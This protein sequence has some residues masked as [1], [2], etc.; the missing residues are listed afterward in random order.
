MKNIYNIIS[1]ILFLL[2]TCCNEKDW[3][4]IS[5]YGAIT[6]TEFNTVDNVEKLCIAAYAAVGNDANNSP[7]S[8]W[9]FNFSVGDAHKGG[10]TPTD[11]IDWHNMEVLSSLVP[12]NTAVFMEWRYRMTNIFRAN[13]ALSKLI[14][15]TAA[16]YPLVVQRTAEMRFLRAFNYFEMKCMF[17]FVPWLD[18]TVPQE[19]YINISNTQF[20]SDQLWD[21]IAAD[22]RFCANNLPAQQTT[23]KGRPDK[24][25]ALAYLAKTYLFQAYTQDNNNQVTGINASK[26]TAVN[27]L[28]D[29]IISFSG[30]SMYADYA[31][32]FLIT[33]NN[34]IESLWDVDFSIN[35]GTGVGRLD[36]GNTV[37]WPMDPIF[38]CCGFHCPTQ[39]FVNAFKTD[40]NGLPC[41]DTF[42]LTPLKT[43]NDFKINN[44][45]PRFS[46]TIIFP[47]FPFKYINTIV[48]TNA[49]ARA[50][51]SY[52]ANFSAK[53]LE[54]P[55]CSCFKKFPPF[56][57]T[58]K[59][60]HLIRFAE[61]LL[62]KAEALIELGRQNEALP[63]INQIRQRAANS[64]GKLKRDDGTPYCTYKCGVYVDGVNCTW[65][66][67]FA[68]KA[69]RFEYRL[70][71]GLEGHRFFDLVRWGIAAD[72]INNYYSTEKLR[73]SVLKDAT[74][75]KSRNE[76]YPIPLSEISYSNG[77]YV[78]NVGY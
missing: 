23:D 17:K 22:F 37:N 28:C 40:A 21:K 42:D 18:E 12:N 13:Y 65:T 48:A 54:S 58:S 72:Y 63:L 14:N 55:Y 44:I 70:E 3:L 73:R 6:A 78:Q 2:L 7:V 76:Y 25:S 33:G 8:R 77:L 16:D 41:L 26:L 53:E 30:H 74:F 47:G 75:T 27:T 11:M 39:N 56:M 20:S 38:G 15:F 68:R 35:D 69:L 71:T 51:E 31:S 45:D 24:Y 32:N 36:F 57:G 5:P 49:W 64:T 1:I 34:G 59:N 10:N 29:S 60:W 66:Q 19:Q 61:I 62:W 46:H 50:I 52:G 9:I 67:A 4:N 43:V